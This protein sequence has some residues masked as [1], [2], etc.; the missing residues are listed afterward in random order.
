M[1]NI[2]KKEDEENNSTNGGIKEPDE[3]IN[4]YR[5]P[6]AFYKLIENR[7]KKR[8]IFLARTLSY[9]AS[10]RKPLWVSPG[11]SKSS[12][13]TNLKIPELLKS[14][15]KQSRLKPI[16]ATFYLKGFTDQQPGSSNREREIPV[17]VGLYESHEANEDTAGASNSTPSS[18]PSSRL[19]SRN[20]SPLQTDSSNKKGKRYYSLLE[21]HALIVPYR[22]H[23]TSSI[24]ENNNG[25]AA[26]FVATN[27]K[28]ELSIDLANYIDKGNRIFLA[29]HVYNPKVKSDPFFF[30]ISTTASQITMPPANERA[31]IVASTAMAHTHINRSDEEEEER[32]ADNNDGNNEDDNDTEEGGVTNKLNGK[33]PS[34]RNNNR[35]SG[36]TRRKRQRRAAINTN[37]NKAAEKKQKSASQRHSSIDSA[38]ISNH[39]QRP[40]RRLQEAI[41]ARNEGRHP[42]MAAFHAQFD[43]VVAK[44]RQGVFVNFQPVK[45]GEYQRVCFPTDS[46]AALQDHPLNKP[47]LNFQLEWEHSGK[48]LRTLKGANMRNNVAGRYRR[49]CLGIDLKRRLS[50][51]PPL[52]ECTPSVSY[53]YQ[54]K[55]KK[56]GTQDVYEI[57]NRAEVREDF[58]CPWCQTYCPDMASL[59]CHLTCSHSH[60]HFQCKGTTNQPEIWVK[61]LPKELEIMPSIINANYYYSRSLP[62][63]RQLLHAHANNNAGKYEEAPLG[64]GSVSNG[65]SNTGSE[66]VGAIRKKQKLNNGKSSGVD[67]LLQVSN[68]GNKQ[69]SQNRNNRDEVNNSSKRTRFKMYTAEG[70]FSS[71]KKTNSNNNQKNNGNFIDDLPTE[72]EDFKAYRETAHLHFRRYYHSKTCQPMEYPMLQEDSDDDVDEEWILEQSEKLLDE[73]EDV[74]L[75]EKHFMKIWNRYIFYNKIFADYQV[76]ERCINFATKHGLELL[77]KKL[78]ENFLLHLLN[79]WDFA[80]I[81]SDTIEKCMIIVDRSDIV[82]KN[83]VKPKN[84]EE[85]KLNIDNAAAK[86]ISIMRSRVGTVKSDILAM[87]DDLLVD[88]FQHLRKTLDLSISDNGED[89]EGDEDDEG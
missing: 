32:I 76:A 69:P 15:V 86:R 72:E 51:L 80:L 20:N 40:T 12:N 45:H 1:S 49:L 84:N 64:N 33:R 63:I 68:S 10:T 54:F 73:F 87:S 11:T 31:R 34:S 37:I 77:Q 29:I 24:V 6:T 25:V 4:A 85:N 5:A 59:V 36:N 28:L 61:V 16:F 48:S 44:S 71:M 78:R 52:S 27:Q 66:I 57:C 35:A 75:E 21:S 3:F 7:G 18:S 62:R 39:R 70:S 56:E 74:S 50:G 38:I 26:K 60:F 42:P 83:N 46:R 43:L 2:V 9:R 53:H 55:R 88:D 30:G 17:T 41:E 8:P 65:A 79:M 22:P 47:L 13:L 19:G 89:D 81:Q 82:E 67:L 23:Q 14:S 58:C